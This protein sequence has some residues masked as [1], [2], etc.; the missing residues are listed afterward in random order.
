MSDEAYTDFD[1][2][3]GLGEEDKGEFKNNRDDWF[4]METGQTVRG[5]FVYFHTLDYNAMAAARKANPKIAP[6]QL[7]EA[8]LKALAERAKELN[9]AVDAL[10]AIDKLDLRS[11]HFKKLM[12][13]YQQGLGYVVSRLG[14]DGKEADDVWKRL[15]DAKKYFTTVLLLY[16]TDRNGEIDRDRFKTNW[17]VKPWRFGQSVYERFWKLNSSLGQLGHSLSTQDLKIEC[18]DAQFQKIDPTFAGQ[19]IWQKNESFRNLVL[20]KA[21]ELYPKLVPFREM[22]TD[23]LRAKL[24][25]GGSAVSDVGAGGDFSDLLDNV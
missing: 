13:H 17:T 7:R 16:P 9:K 11:V 6:D 8:G 20:E 10:T 5:A 18:K 14:K 4:K 21:L 24:G 1:D 22:T 25:L 3:V 19:A 12:G 2:D 23:Q 15:P